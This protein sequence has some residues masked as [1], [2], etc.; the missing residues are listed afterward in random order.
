MNAYR[1]YASLVSKLGILLSVQFIFGVKNDKP[2][3]HIS[4]WDIVPMPTNSRNNFACGCVYIINNVDKISTQMALT[5]STEVWTTSSRR[6]ISDQ[7]P[8]CLLSV[9]GFQP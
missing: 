8:Q 4:V 9:D 1:Q 7:V 6:E 2:F 3:M 5:L